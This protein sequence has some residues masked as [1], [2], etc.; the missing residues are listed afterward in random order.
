[1]PNGLLTETPTRKKKVDEYQNSEIKELVRYSVDEAAVYAITF[2]AENSLVVAA[3]DGNLRRL[4]AAGELVA[5]FPAVEV[6]SDALVASSP[7]DAKAWNEMLTQRIEN[8]AVEAAP[9]IERVKELIIEPSQIE[10]SSPYAYSQLVVTAVLDDGGTVD[11]TR[12]S[13]IDVPNWATMTARGLVRPASDGA[14]TIS[15]RYGKQSQSIKVS[16]TGVRG[17][18]QDHGAVDYIRDVSPIMSRLGCNAGTCHGAQKG[19]NGFK[20]SLRGYDPVLRSSCLDR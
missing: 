10:F 15:V 5:T 6:A 14:G 20:L 4:D 8:A 19:K 13:E 18:G 3:D 12:L 11:V 2:A 1:M 17:D 9:P 7:F 16:A